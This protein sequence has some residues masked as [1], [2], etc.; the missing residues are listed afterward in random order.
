L[1]KKWTLKKYYLFCCVFFPLLGLLIRIFYVHHFKWGL[2]VGGDYIWYRNVALLISKGKFFI[3]P[4]FKQQIFPPGYP[5]ALHP[6]LYPLV[7]A[8][9]DFLGLKTIHEQLL[10]N[11]LEGSLM[12]FALMLAGAEID[13]YAVG[14]ISGLI[15]SISPALLVYDGVGLSEQTE[16]L[17]VSF[18]IFMSYK[19]YKTPSFKNVA[20]LGCLI[21]LSSMVRSEQ[22]LMVLTIGLP[23]FIK[24]RRQ[25]IPFFVKA[26]A[27]A[28]GVFLIV[29]PWVIRNIV[30]FNPPETFSSQ[31]GITLETANCKQTYYG[32]LVGYWDFECYKG[33]KVPRSEAGADQVWRNVALNYIKGHFLR[34]IEI[35]P[36]RVG[37]ILYI[38]NPFQQ[39]ALNQFEGWPIQ[40][41]RINVYFGW[42]E[43]LLA[44][45][46]IVVLVKKGVWLAPLTAQIIL[47]LLVAIFIYGNSRYRSSFE[48]SLVLLSAVA[49][50]EI[51]LFV[52]QFISKDSLKRLLFSAK[53]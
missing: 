22:I 1:F 3:F 46:G 8:F 21:G 38:Y 18:V 28:G 23:L 25:I 49:I 36:Y 19:T 4:K 52:S 30:I 11:C 33:I 39:A 47:V 9:F 48:L 50:K 7:L 35:I 5:T 41:G 14:I 37:R 32:A 43:E 42:I 44:L 17:V 51:G 29:S 53:I 26:L 45:V 31:L 6:P 12:V 15:S 16:M 20:I 10:I 34:F 27:F 40:L 13:G 24:R 2:T